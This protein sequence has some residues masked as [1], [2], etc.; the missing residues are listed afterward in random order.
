[1]EPIQPI[2]DA[3]SHRQLAQL[4][5]SAAV[6]SGT[7]EVNDGREA[8]ADRQRELE[9]L[10]QAYGRLSVQLLKALEGNTQE[11]ARGRSPRQLMAMG[12]LRAH[13][14]MALQALNAHRDRGA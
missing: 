9:A 6:E 3:I 12:A 5:D 1:M 11:L 8:G 13:A 10:L 7:P 2:P 14:Q 4:L